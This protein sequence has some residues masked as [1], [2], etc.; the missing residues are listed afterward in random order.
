M[1]SPIKGARFMLLF[2]RSK[3]MLT[4]LL[5]QALLC[6]FVIGMLINHNLHP[7]PVGVIDIC[8]S[9]KN[10]NGLFYTSSSYSNQS[11]ALLIKL[12]LSFCQAALVVECIFAW[13]NLSRRLSLEMFSAS[14]ISEAPIYIAMTCLVQR[15]LTALTSKQSLNGNLGV[16]PNLNK[17]ACLL[18]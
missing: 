18:H 11:S 17:R 15:R 4:A 6:A 8:W 3:L 13:I 7:N 12:A 9:C 5:A 14:K 10:R 1:V 2:S 16:F